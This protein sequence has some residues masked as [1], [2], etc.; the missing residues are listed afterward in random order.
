MEILHLVAVARTIF[1]LGIINLITALLI[2]SSCRCIPGS[3]IGSKLMQHRPFKGFYKYHCY[4]W[5]VF[6][7]SVIVHA[8]LAIT[9][10]GWP[11]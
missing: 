2:F 10:F 9:Y 5:R 3:R 1:I 4:I 7:P 8:F 11:A 6:W